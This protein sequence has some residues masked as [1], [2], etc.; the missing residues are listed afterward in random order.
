M[1]SVVHFEIPVKDDETKQ[2]K[3]YYDKQKLQGVPDEHIQH[4]LPLKLFNPVG[5]IDSKDWG[6][7][8]RGK[9]PIKYGNLLVSAGEEGYAMKKDLSRFSIEEKFERIEGTTLGKAL[10]SCKGN[11]QKIMVW[12]G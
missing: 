6:I 7:K 4:L 5:G 11:K 9:V 2:S 3:F 1:N 12:V 10:E 8:I